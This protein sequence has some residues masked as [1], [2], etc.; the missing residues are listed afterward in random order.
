[1]VKFALIIAHLGVPRSGV[2]VRGAWDLAFGFVWF[3]RL[4]FKSI[5]D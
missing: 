2:A 4:T 3:Y 5:R 1:M